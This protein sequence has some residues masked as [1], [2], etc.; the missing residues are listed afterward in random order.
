M[1]LDNYYGVAGGTQKG[2]VPLAPWLKEIKLEEGEDLFKDMADLN[3]DPVP[4]GLDLFG[5][6]SHTC[7]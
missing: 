7:F 2:W 6:K 3:N 1:D 4:S 5:I